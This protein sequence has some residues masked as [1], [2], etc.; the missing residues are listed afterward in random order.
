MNLKNMTNTMSM[1]MTS[2]PR[3]GTLRAKY[4]INPSDLNVLL[5]FICVSTMENARIHVRNATNRLLNEETWTRTSG[6]I[7]A[8]NR[9]IARFVRGTYVIFMILVVAPQQN[10]SDL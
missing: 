1:N 3:K 4:A 9:S 6:F 7:L 5:I 10:C 2:L 8:K